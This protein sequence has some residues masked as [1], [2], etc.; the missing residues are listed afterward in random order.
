MPRVIHFELP[1]DNPQRAVKFYTDVFGWKI[2]KWPGPQDYWL[3]TTGGDAEPGIN[4][5]IMK[6]SQ[7]AVTVNTIGVPSADEYIEKVTAAGGRVVAPKMAVPGVGYAAYLQDT[8]G[9]TFALM[10]EDKSAR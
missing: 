7:G 2:E 6:R 3:V 9:N 1:A 5:A 8:E 10:Q 4:G